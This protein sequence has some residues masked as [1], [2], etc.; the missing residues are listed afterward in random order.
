MNYELT[1]MENEVGIPTNIAV[2]HTPNKWKQKCIEGN[3]ICVRFIR[4][5]EWN[6][7]KLSGGYEEWELFQISN[8][9]YMQSI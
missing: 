3:R 4:S 7:D 5:D 9:F 8:L 6:A 1:R 2:Q